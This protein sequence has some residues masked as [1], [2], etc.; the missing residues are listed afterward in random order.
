M[1][2]RKNGLISKIINKIWEDSLPYKL[3][4]TP[5]STIT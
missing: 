4:L 1:E 3:I 5:E 2:N